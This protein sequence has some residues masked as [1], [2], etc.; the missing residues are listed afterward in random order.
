[1]NLIPNA[2]TKK[3]ICKDKSWF[4]MIADKMIR[5]DTKQYDTFMNGVEY[6]FQ[7]FLAFSLQNCVFR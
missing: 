5:Y 6:S 1:M 4:V 2:E 7:P 3:E